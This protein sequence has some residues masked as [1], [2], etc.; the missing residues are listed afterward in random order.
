MT[1]FQQAVLE[2]FND[3]QPSTVQSGRGGR[4]GLPENRFDAGP[5]GVHQPTFSGEHDAFFSAVST[6]D[7]ATQPRRNGLATKDSR[8]F[9]TIAFILYIKAKVRLSFCK[10]SK[11]ARKRGSGASW[12]RP[13]AHHLVRIF[14]AVIAKKTTPGGRESPNPVSSFELVSSTAHL[15]KTPIRGKPH[16]PSFRSD[17]S[18]LPAL[19]P[20]QERAPTPPCRFQDSGRNAVF[21]CK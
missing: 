3:L 14:D 10:R 2:V 19:P 7:R 6:F 21:P 8:S 16:R 4:S 18:P 20:H 11:F 9:F 1:R 13:G 15:T 5:P 12:S 17:R